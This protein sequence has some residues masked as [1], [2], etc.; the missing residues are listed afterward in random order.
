M[1]FGITSDLGIKSIYIGPA[2]GWHGYGVYGHTNLI[3]GEK[4]SSSDVPEPGT[5]ALVGIALAGAG[6]ARRRKA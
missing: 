1:F 3:M 4:G 6:V 2:N 5:L